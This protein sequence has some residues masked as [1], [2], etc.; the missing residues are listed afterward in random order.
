MRNSGIGGIFLISEDLDEISSSSDSIAVIYHGEVTAPQA[1]PYRGLDLD[2]TADRAATNRRG[3][4]RDAQR[5]A[6]E[7][8][9]VF[10]AIVAMSY[11]RCGR[12]E[13]VGQWHAGRER[14]GRLFAGSIGSVSGIEASLVYATEIS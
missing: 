10:L 7:G 2:R 11:A 6:V 12:P 9:S 3:S 8:S 4:T 1:T 13:V 14:L 5:S